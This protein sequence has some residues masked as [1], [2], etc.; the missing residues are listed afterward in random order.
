MPVGIPLDRVCLRSGVYCSVCE[1]KIREGRFDEWEIDVMKALVD[2]EPS[3]GGAQLDYVKAYRTGNA[4]VIVANVKGSVP[5]VVKERL[6]KRLGVSDVVIVSNTS[7]IIRLAEE[8]L[9]P[10]R[11]TGIDRSYLPDGTVET[12]LRMEGEEPP[13]AWAVALFKELA[14]KRLGTEVK[15]RYEPRRV[16]VVTMEKPDLSKVSRLFGP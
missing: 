13:R 15:I 3:L 16:S 11:V 9:Y 4:V 7:D 5:V 8:L 14:R 1:R 6:A 10:L 2:L 12:I